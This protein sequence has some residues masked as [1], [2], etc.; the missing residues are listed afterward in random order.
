MST[1]KKTPPR[2]SEEEGVV[3]TPEQLRRRRARN[4]AIASVLGFLA[5]LFYVVTIVKLG[6]NVLNRP[7]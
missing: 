4:I 5:V 7:L 2:P 1:G 3:L 6:P